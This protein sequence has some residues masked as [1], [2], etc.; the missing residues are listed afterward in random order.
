VLVE[1]LQ[2]L[3]LDLTAHKIVEPVE[4]IDQVLGYLTHDIID[5]VLA[6][7]L[8]EQLDRYLVE[9]NTLRESDLCDSKNMRQFMKERFFI[10]TAHKAKG[11]EFESVIVFNAVEGSYPFRN[12]LQSGNQERIREDARRFYV[13]LSRAKKHLCITFS[14]TNRFGNPDRPT[15]FLKSIAP[16]FRFYAFN[17]TSGRIDEIENL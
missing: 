11:L 13:A 9:I 5:P 4:K 6:P 3:Y 7:T 14:D 16:M 2:Y 1:T 17:P 12:N 10:A 8:R 15:P